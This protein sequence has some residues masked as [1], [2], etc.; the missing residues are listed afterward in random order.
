M[1]ETARFE[2]GAVTLTRV[3]YFDVAL[4]PA[5]VGLTPDEVAAAPDWCVPT[6]T[7]SEGEVL[8]GQ[9]IWV[10]ESQ[11]RVVA[12]DP[13]GASD[14]FLRSGAEAVI[15]QEAVLAAM[16]EAGYPAERVD[17]VVL[18]HLDGIGMTAV[19]DDDGRWTPAFPSARI[20]LTSAE[21][22]FLAGRDDVGGVDQLRSLVALGAV[23]GVAG[24]HRL[25][26]EVS[27]RL[28]GGHSPGHALIEVESQGERAVFIGHLAINPIHLSMVAGE[29]AHV[30]AV[31]TQAVIDEV[32][33]TAADDGSLVIGPLWPFPGAGQVTSADRRVVPAF[34]G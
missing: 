31:V 19:V 6:W 25:T 28:C 30:D 9:V 18:S 34:V 5:A 13:C 17:V 11:G 2:I 4:E 27:L 12:V 7:T 1:V 33:A 15:H 24:D 32:L 23:D 22:D 16:A 21:L 26:D 29:G 3:P 10:I 20:L 14:P 8:V